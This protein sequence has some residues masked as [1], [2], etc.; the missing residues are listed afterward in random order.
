MRLFSRKMVIQL[1][2]M[3]Q[4][5]IDEVRSVG[6][7]AWSDLYSKEFHQNFQVPK[8][9]AR[10]VAFYMDKEPEGCIVAESDGRVVGAV[11]CHVW[12]KVGW[13]GPVEVLPNNQNAGVGK[14]LITGAISYLEN[15]GCSVIGLETMPETM[16]NVV[17]YSNLGFYPDRVTYLMEKSLY[18]PRRQDVFPPPGTSIVRYS[19]MGEEAAL[20]AVK[21][22][23]C[24]S[25]PELDYS[26]EVYYSM[27]HNT[28]ETLFLTRGEEPLG[29][30]LVYTYSTSDGSNNSSIRIMMLRGSASVDTE[31]PALISAGEE[32]AREN[33]KERMNI[34][35][36]TGS[37][38]IF[39]ILRSS[40]YVLKGTNI[41]MLHRGSIPS[42]NKV[43]DLNSWAG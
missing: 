13:F 2:P 19:E 34:R 3:R 33:E 31:A 38:S 17:L 26:R 29:F 15:R 6:Q 23:S 22:L 41:R 27:K 40:S 8:R 14:K 10:N 4:D 39:N 37:Y 18:A 43:I 12:G 30:A 16:K 7:S 28:G 20:N 35:F 1:R 5:D 21:T 42:L 11:F 25:M 24:L 32:F 36:Y 9:S